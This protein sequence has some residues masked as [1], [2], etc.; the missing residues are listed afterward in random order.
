MA[1]PKPLDK[2]V[3]LFCKAGAFS[4]VVAGTSVNVKLSWL[5]ELE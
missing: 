2:P 1:T 4:S 5:R 3:G